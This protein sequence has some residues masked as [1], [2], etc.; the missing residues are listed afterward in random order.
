MIPNL[1]LVKNIQARSMGD[2]DIP[3]SVGY[4]ATLQRPDGTF[5]EHRMDDLAYQAHACDLFF[6]PLMFRG[7]R[8]NDNCLRAGVLFADL[9]RA[10]YPVITPSV[11]WGTS[12]GNSQAV[13]YLRY[14]MTDMELWRQLNQWMT[15]ETGA[16]RGGWM[17]SKLL[18]VPGTLNY[19]RREFPGLVKVNE[20]VV[21]DPED[22][23]SQMPTP[24]KRAGKSP[25]EAVGYPQPLN[26]TNE[27]AWLLRLYWHKMGIKGRNMVCRSRVED[28]SRH[29]YQ[30]AR[31]LGKNSKMRPDEIFRIIWVAPWCKWRLMDKPEQLWNDVLKAID[32]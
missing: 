26:S 16:D 3:D 20:G 29:I 24:K 32:A 25:L 9:D 13:W 2:T 8:S 23:L 21:Y 1:D 19:K 4:L 14:P 6:T 30:T 7:K 22:L 28:R 10:E 15:I 18:R 5:N 17:Q 27:Q 12:A 11:W 31:E